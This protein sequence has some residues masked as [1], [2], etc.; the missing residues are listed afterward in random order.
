M[1]SIRVE[2]FSRLIPSG[3]PYGY[4][5]LIRGDLGM[6]KTL[7]VK[8]IARSILAKYPLIYVAFDDDPASIIGEFSS[9]SQNLYIIDGFNVEPAARGLPN[10]VGS[11]AELDPRQIVGMVSNSLAKAKARGIVIDSI[12]DMLMNME[13]RSLL[14]LLK[15]LKA[16]TR[17]FNVLT[18]VIAHTTSE[19]VANLLNN[20]E[21][22]FDGIVEV[23]LDP[24]LAQVGV[25]V[26]RMRVKRLS[27]LSHSIDWYYFTISR[28]K[29]TPVNVEELKKALMAMMEEKE[30]EQ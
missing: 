14:Y 5:I 28:G 20:M 13:P 11:V 12:N 7:M 21:Y 24:N 27:G 30:A 22:V 8:L 26:R 9:Y 2:P 10:I 29:I 3:L 15:G 23:E 19:D 18:A 25:P 4:M 17:R 1:E 6:G 16:V